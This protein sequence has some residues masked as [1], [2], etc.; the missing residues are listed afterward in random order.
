[1]PESR[2]SQHPI[3]IVVMGGIGA[4]K[5]TVGSLLGELGARVIDADRVGHE[6]LEPGG[7]AFPAVAERWPQVVIGGRIDRAVLASIVFSDLDQLAELEAIT[8][9]AIGRT[10][11]ARAAAAGERPVVVELPLMRRMLGAG[12]IW[13]VVDAPDEMR[14][15]RAV[16][17]GGDPE[18]V[19]RR[20][21]AQPGRAEWLEGAD[22]IIT[23][24]GDRDSLISRVRVVWDLVTSPDE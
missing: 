6:V 16:A 3:R 4:G 21:A 11:E 24:D 8:H 13:V 17:R 20:M 1:M 7:A 10:I 9:P 19:Q 22:H 23:N 12:W 5:S 15:A 2:P 14:L 18:D